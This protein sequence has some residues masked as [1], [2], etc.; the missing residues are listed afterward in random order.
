[1]DSVAKPPPVPRAQWL[2]GFRAVRQLIANPDDIEKAQDFGFYIGHRDEERRFQRFVSSVE[3]QQLLREGT[4]LLS[5]LADRAA[6]AELPPDSLGRAYLV[7]LE[8]NG[9]AP[10]S[11]QVLRRSAQARWERSEDAPPLDPTRAWFRDRAVLCHDLFHV[12]TGYGTDHVG[13]ATL[14][15]FCAAEMRSRA[16]ALLALGAFLEVW[17]SAGRGW[18]VY[19]YRAWKRGRGAKHLVAQPWEKLLSLPLD[20]V[21]GTT[22]VG[23]PTAAHPGGILAGSR[24][25]AGVI[26]IVNR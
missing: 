10:E 6:L 7:Y 1:M 11:L 9:F 5:A 21:R 25:E 26:R 3:G 8:E 22:A 2:R 20:Q 14:L 19:A 18:L 12:A 24:D 13:E 17:R 15:I 4:S 16:T 23:A